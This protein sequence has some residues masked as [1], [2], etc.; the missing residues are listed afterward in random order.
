MIVVSNTSPIL[1]LAAV[2]QLE[3]LPRLYQKVVLPE[4]VSAELTLGDSYQPGG[5]EMQTPPW[6]ETRT[7]TDQA[8]VT[9]VRTGT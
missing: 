5:V 7:V 6:L 1:N 3:I 2:G 8:F 9:A 4:A